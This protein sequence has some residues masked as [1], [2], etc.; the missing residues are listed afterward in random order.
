MY[1][2]NQL[3]DRRRRTG[4]VLLLTVLSIIHAPSRSQDSQAGQVCGKLF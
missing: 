2:R 4:T 3:R 1:I